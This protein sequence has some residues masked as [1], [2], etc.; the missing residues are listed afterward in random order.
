[1]KKSSALSAKHANVFASAM[2]LLTLISS[3]ATADQHSNLPPITQSISVPAKIM[4]LQDSMVSA[5]IAANVDAINA[6]VGDKI[7][8]GSVL[9]TLDCREYTI[10][11]DLAN[12]E[13]NSLRAKLPSI[14]A[15]IEA[16]KSDVAANK[17]SEGLY[18]TQA[19]AAQ[20]SVTAGKADVKRIRAQSKAEQAKCNLARLDLKRAQ[21]LGK[22]QV[23]SQQELDKALTE[24]Q[25]AQAECSAI[26]PEIASANAKTQ[27]LQASA[28]AAQVATKVQQA[29]TKM[30]ST[31]IK[32]QE[33]EI[34][35]LNA[36][37]AAAEAK[38]RTAALMVSRCELK[39]PFDGEII[40]RKVQ[41][42]Q[43][44]AVGEDA[45][46]ILSIQDREI[47]A[48]VS[49]AELQAIKDT[50]NLVFSTPQHKHPIR[51]RAA[52]GMLDG[53]ARTREVRFT[54]TEEN[55]L[56]IGTSGRVISENQK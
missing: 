44:I 39:A 20:A 33:A 29:K 28:N 19:K 21:D 3:S 36:Q 40:E 1:M 4:S 10:N 41:M 32:V 49:E 17:E 7:K 25:A 54:F 43:R 56:A 34:P 26:Q 46:R 45:F 52:V 55:P 27:S 24:Y 31:N 53:E 48:S 35:A 37:I 13:I 9:A 22:R 18:E 16:A 2:V 6:D 8:K 50:P 12:A 38:S 5:E 51:F 11:E 30:A 15:R 23:I 14:Q 47:S 42:G